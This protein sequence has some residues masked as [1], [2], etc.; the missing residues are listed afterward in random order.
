MNPPTSLAHLS[1]SFEVQL[2]EVHDNL[3][4]ENPE[5]AINMAQV[6]PRSTGPSSYPAQSLPRSSPSSHS[7]GPL[8]ASHFSPPPSP[9][10]LHHDSS[11]QPSGSPILHDSP[12]GSEP[13][14]SP[15]YCSLLPGPRHSGTDSWPLP[16]TIG[17]KESP[18][19]TVSLTYHVVHDA[20]EIAR[21]IHT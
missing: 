1:L 15:P 19:D 10:L 4:D 17:F 3:G 9:P 2:S 6:T 14:P 13:P 11:P 12:H 20:G 5:S 8:P 18:S 7:P 21:R 16:A